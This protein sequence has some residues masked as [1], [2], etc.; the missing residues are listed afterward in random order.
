MHRSLWKHL[1]HRFP[2]G[3]LRPQRTASLTNIPSASCGGPKSTPA[4]CDLV[5][6]LWMPCLKPTLAPKWLA[7]EPSFPSHYVL[8][9]QTSTKYR[10]RGREASRE[11]GCAG[12][13]GW[14][15]G[16]SWRRGREVMR[17]QCSPFFTSVHWMPTDW[18]YV[19]FSKRSHWRGF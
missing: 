5:M 13:S 4:D 14:W 3:L 2:A 9:R 16:G 15:W 19:I 11:Q 7:L 17:A 8:A 6:G 1:L 18:M 10:K 12:G